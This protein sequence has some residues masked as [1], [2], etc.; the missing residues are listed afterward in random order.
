MP[1]V[2]LLTFSTLALAC[3]F[4]VGCSEDNQDTNNNTETVQT[5]EMKL[6]FNQPEEHPEFIALENFGKKLYEATDGRYTLDVVPN[7]LLGSQKETIEM[8]QNGTL[9]FS[10]VAGSLMDSWNPDF[11]VLNLP[12]V[13]KDYK[14]LQRVVQDPTIVGDLW[15]SIEDKGLRVVCA[16]YT[17]TRN[18]YTRDKPILSPE[19][20]KDLKIRVIQA[21]TMVKMV[22][23]MDGIGTPMAQSEVYTA[24]QTG[25][26]DG[27]ENNEVTYFVLKHPEVAPYYSKTAHATMPDYL[28]TN[29]KYF[30]ALPDEVKNF[31]A[32]NINTLIS[33]EFEAF[34]QEVNIALS[35]A[36][37]EGAKIYDVDIEPFKKAVEPLIAEKL[38][39]PSA[40]ALYDAIQS[41]RDIE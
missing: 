3:M 23:R 7:E 21:D 14:H 40:K 28:L 10:L 37:K 20:L 6:A 13:F 5:I 32:E 36:V 30:D 1:K 19:D 18:I 11:V 35:N 26:L 25:M 38:Q 41:K 16:L 4:L 29:P 33:E 2:K 12:Y 31:F 39:S 24:I 27:A 17:G 15:N 22:N 9:P 8:V 34:H